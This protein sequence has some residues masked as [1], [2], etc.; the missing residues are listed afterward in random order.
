M[1]SIPRPLPPYFLIRVSK[2]AEKKSKS[3]IGSF[4]LPETMAFMA[5]NT[6]W[7]E[8]VAIGDRA[9]S[10]FPEAKVGHILIV[11]HFV[12]QGSEDEA[13]EEHLIHWDEEYNYYIVTAY[14]YAGKANETYGVWDGEKIIPNKDYIFLE[15]KKP[16]QSDLPPDEALNQSLKVTESGL[17]VFDEW[18]ETREQKEEKQ[19]ELKRQ[20]EELAKSGTN[21]LHVNQAIL[22]NQWEAEAISIEVNKQEYK[23]YTV[24]A[25]NKQL[26]EWF[27]RDVVSGDTM[28]LLNLAA[29][30]TIGF[31]GETYIVSKTKFI[32]CLY[33][34]ATA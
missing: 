7:G 31:N 6:Q 23:F 5:H 24:A 13:R 19:A 25:A 17:L 12:Q 8:I 18:E 3:T 9:A 20:T 14:E 30:T 27:G 26:S 33:D 11:H 22:T 4:I 34:K 16:K 32:G 10:Y 28:G 21:K 15:T 1:T 2:E 29:Q